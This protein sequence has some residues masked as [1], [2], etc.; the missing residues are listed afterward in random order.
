MK[1][2]NT[3]VKKYTKT[4]PNV[5]VFLV[6]NNYISFIEIKNQLKLPI[7]TPKYKIL[8][9]QTSKNVGPYTWVLSYFVQRYSVLSCP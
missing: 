2:S 1:I 3:V 5:I 4:K 6:I 7:S 9:Y 8:F